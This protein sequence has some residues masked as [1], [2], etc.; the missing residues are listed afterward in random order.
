MLNKL[1]KAVIE[2]RG[3]VERG[4][5]TFPPADYA[6][7]QHRVGQFEAYTEVLNMIE[8]LKRKEDEE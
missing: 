4:T 5:F 8:Q 3:E 2:K 1:I 6:K 7:F